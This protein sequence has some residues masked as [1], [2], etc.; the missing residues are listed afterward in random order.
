ME[1]FESRGVRLKTERGNRVFPESDRAMDV[2]DAMARLIKRKNIKLV[3]GKTVKDI[4]E[5][6]GKVESVVLSDGKEIKA[7]AV[8]IATG[9]ASYQ[10]T[11]SCCYGDV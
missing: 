7:D 2:V 8:I 9:G 10:R 5:K 6:N 11:G 4:K 1:M 3:T